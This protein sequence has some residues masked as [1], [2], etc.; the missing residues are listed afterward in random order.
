MRIGFDLDGVLYD[1]VN[2][3]RVYMV[4]H[5]GYPAYR[6]GASTSW[7]FFK[8]NWGMTTDEFLS[9][10]EDGV[11]AGV[12]FTHGNIEEGAIDLLH[13]LREHGHTV[14]IVTHRTIGSKAQQATVDWLSREGFEWDSLTFSEDK[15]IIKTDIFIEDKVENF[16]DLEESGVRSFIMDRAWNQHLSTPYRVNSLKDF[17]RCVQWINKHSEMRRELVP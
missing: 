10:Y 15:T 2:A 14:H 3:L 4:H 8:D 13:S 5:R 9:I 17:D 11:N 1:F 6:L 12:V 16:L 7:N